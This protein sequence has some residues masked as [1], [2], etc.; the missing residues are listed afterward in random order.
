M[1]RRDFVQLS[2]V[3]AALAA[4]GRLPLLAAPVA[5][6]SRNIFTDPAAIEPVSGA[7]RTFIPV[8]DVFPSGKDREW[9]YDLVSWEGLQK[10]GCARNVTSGSLTVRSSGHAAYTV[11]QRVGLSGARQDTFLNVELK[12]DGESGSVRKWAVTSDFAEFN[13]DKIAD[14]SKMELTGQYDGSV[15]NLRGAEMRL[16]YS[17][18]GPLLCPWM[19]P[20]LLARM[21]SDGRRSLRF[22]LL[23]DGLKIRPEQEL[24]YEG[25]VQVPV[26]SGAI[27]LHIWMQT[28][29]GI[30]PVHWMLDDAGRTQLMTHSALNW[31]LKSIA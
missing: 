17:V 6:V 24:S 8:S 5:K 16:S 31:V 1:N 2:S 22:T 12:T 3:A 25:I 28:G 9:M 23:D 15:V 27:P 14:D 13:G 20:D 4:S 7:M 18:E 21:S 30:L 10:D 19:L 26:K 29:R 11:K